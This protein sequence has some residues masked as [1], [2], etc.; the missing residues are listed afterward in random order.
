M[1]FLVSR[2]AAAAVALFPALAW[3]D[4]APSLIPSRDVDITYRV[5][6]AGQPNVSERVRWLAA[7]KLERI[8]I[9][10]SL[11]TI[12]DHAKNDFVILQPKQRQVIKGLGS[13]HDSTV[14]D[15]GPAAERGPVLH[16][17][18]LDCTEWTWSDADG[19]NRV[20]VTDDGVILQAQIG[21]STTLKAM[22]VVYG[23]LKPALFEVPL[24]YEPTILPEN[25]EP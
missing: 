10:E 17:K 22:K 13:P 23:P 2:A 20:C 5:K 9:P 15:V 8:D 21:N 24:N 14:M 6:R 3:A 25:V 7:R 1:P 16:V 11:T 12:V 4:P 18:A 19:Q